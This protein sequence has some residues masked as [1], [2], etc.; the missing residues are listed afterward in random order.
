MYII[1]SI[2]CG[3]N[4]VQICRLQRYEYKKREK[5]NRKEWTEKRLH[6]NYK[7]EA[8]EQYEIEPF[9]THHTYDDSMTQWYFLFLL[10]RFSLTITP[11]CVFPGWFIWAV[12]QHCFIGLYFVLLLL[13]MLVFDRVPNVFLPNLALV[14]FFIS[15]ELYCAM[16]KHKYRDF[17][18]SK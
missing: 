2:D 18:S 9:A 11:M 3:P 7:Q 12:E 10:F 15:I 5:K 8:Q 13:L 16:T 14:L 4:G 17:E 1:W 6:T